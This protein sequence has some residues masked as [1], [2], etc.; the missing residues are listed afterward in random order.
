MGSWASL[1]GCHHWKAWSYSYRSAPSLQ[2][3]GC[4]P[5]REGLSVPC[6]LLGLSAASSATEPCPR[7]QIPGKKKECG[8]RVGFTVPV[9]PDW[10]VQP[11]VL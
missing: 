10:E 5:L 7:G 2:G 9:Q 4:L 1:A 3:W 8:A 11:S 6:L